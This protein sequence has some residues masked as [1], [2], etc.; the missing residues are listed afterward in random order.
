MAAPNA[1]YASRPV[2]IDSFTATVWLARRE[3]IAFGAPG[4]AVACASVPGRGDVVVFADMLTLNDGATSKNGAPVL[5]AA[6]S[7]RLRNL[8]PAFDVC[9]ARWI[10]VASL[11]C[12]DEMVPHLRPGGWPSQ[13]L[14]WDVD[15]KPMFADSR[16]PGTRDAMLTVPGAS[17]AWQC[18]AKMVAPFGLCF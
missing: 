2:V 18:V 10:H 17:E 9:A 5:L 14:D 3:P 16:Q 6:L 12:V 4:I 7:R 8:A 11:G 15:W 13:A 1:V